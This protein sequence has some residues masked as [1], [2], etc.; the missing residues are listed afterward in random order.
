M[1]RFS[2]VKKALYPYIVI[3]QTIPIIFIYPLIMIWFGYG[4]HVRIIVVTLVC[5]FPIALNFVDALGAAS[6]ELIALFRSMGATSWQLFRMVKFPG[7]MAGLFSGLKI[8]ATYSVMGAVIGEW[9]GASHGMGVYMMRAYKSFA[10]DR[11]FA[12]IIIVVL[13]SLLF[14]Q[15]VKLIEKLSLPWM[16]RG[17]FNIHKRGPS[18]VQSISE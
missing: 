13:L 11:V 1:D 6:S 12:A 8:A 7:A 4:I 14:F 10:T 17:G 5:F 9:L 18:E 2:Q 15:G 3:S 16:K